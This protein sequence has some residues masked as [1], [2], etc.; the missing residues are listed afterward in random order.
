MKQVLE[1]YEE[2]LRVCKDL[3]FYKAYEYLEEN[4][5]EIGICFYCN[6]KKI[7]YKFISANYI[8]TIPQECETHAEIIESLEFRINFLKELL[9][10]EKN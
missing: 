7:P 5:L 4:H 9:C 2:A 6:I 8:C 1:A 10:E 3:D